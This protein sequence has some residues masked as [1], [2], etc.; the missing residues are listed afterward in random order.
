[1]RYFI[2]IK[3]VNIRFKVSRTLN[4]LILTSVKVEYL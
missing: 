1:M 3:Y 2:A 4:H